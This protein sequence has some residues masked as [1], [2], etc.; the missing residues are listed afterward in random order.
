[1]PA[2]T[3]SRKD[4]TVGIICALEFE[5]VAVQATFDEEH[6]RVHTS[7]WDGNV[8]DFGRIHEHHVVVACL[9]EAV[10]ANVD[11]ATVAADMVRS[12]PIKLLLT[13]G[14]G[15]GVWNDRSDIRLGDIVV[16]QRRPD[17]SH[18]QR[19]SDVQEW[20]GVT[21]RTG[22]L[23]QY[24]QPL[25]DALQ[26]LERTLAVKDG[27]VA[28]NI[29]D[30]LSVHPRMDKM[31][32]HQ[33]Q[34]N[35]E[36]F[37]AGYRHAGEDTCADCDRSHLV[38]NRT[39]RIHDGPRIHYGNIASVFSDDLVLTYAPSRDHTAKEQ[40]ILCF[41]MEA[42][43]L[44]DGFPCVV[45]RGIS[46]YADS[47]RNKRWQGYAAATA[48][49]YAKALL[50]CIPVA[51]ITTVHSEIGATSRLVSGSSS[52]TDRPK[53][54]SE[55]VV[56]IPMLKSHQFAGR[57][58]ELQILKRRILTEPDCQR[59]AVFGPSGVGKTQLVLSFAYWVAEHRPDVSV[60]WISALSAETFDRGAQGIE[61]A[62]VF[63][64]YGRD[65]SM[66]K[67]HL[68]TPK[69][70]KWLLVVDDAD[71][72]ELLEP[73]IR[74]NGLLRY[75]P[76]SP[77]GVTIF[78]T[79][80]SSFA[81]RLAGRDLLRLK[82]PT[83]DEAAELLSMALVDGDSLK[84]PIAA[85]NLLTQLGHEP[86]AITK[87]ATYIND[88]EVSISEYSRLFHSTEPAASSALD[89]GAN[90]ESATS[91]ALDNGTLKTQARHRRTAG[92]YAYPA[93]AISTVHYTP[94]DTDSLPTSSAP[95]GYSLSLQIAKML[96]WLQRIKPCYLMIALGCLAIGGSLAV[97]I[98]YSVSEDRMGDGFTTAGWMVAVSTLVLAAPMAMHYQHCRCWN[99]HKSVTL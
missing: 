45:I 74:S 90:A 96:K 58:A 78:T 73:S 32:R 84:D 35:D 77:L 7:T 79:R 14:I 54:N 93:A 49:A 64:S 60:F 38:H 41:E 55:Q 99:S 43:D 75:L 40:G 86:L 65:A 44:M 25:P 89:T 85:T 34:E 36:L 56:Y 3:R 24:R 72:T 87:A 19:D 57:L 9:S 88:N 1:M 71:D 95:H 27:Q 12:F 17:G 83:R 8:Y 33:G 81:Q 10:Y 13:V 22:L 11:T 92:P 39:H 20:N 52:L 53:E 62:L 2:P 63:R 15:G 47:H 46:D 18:V 42:A 4:Y 26:S 70:G 5:S 66:L 91:S 48:A 76:E 6:G 69:A 37:L 59:L 23:N 51:D 50:M 94:H 30:M 61:I 28:A 21:P 68:N 98:F 29:A 31:F 80:T 67:E 16:S 97:G 82:N